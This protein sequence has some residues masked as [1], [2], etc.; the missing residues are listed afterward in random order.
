MTPKAVQP[1]GAAL[2]LYQGYRYIIVTFINGTGKPPTAQAELWWQGESDTP[3]P[4]GHPS[5]ATSRRR[6]RLEQECQRLTAVLATG[7]PLPTVLDAL[8]E[9]GRQRAALQAQLD[10]LKG[11]RRAAVRWADDGLAAELTARL[12]EWQ[13]VLSGQPVLSRQ[14]LRKLLVGR[15]QLTPHL[16]ADGRCYRWTGHASYGRLLAG[17][18]G[19][20]TMVPPG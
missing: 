14:I 12:G 1:S 10:H 11:L 17:L 16:S 4:S 8:R 9:R 6:R 19:V 13:T 20:Q 15:L 3:L 2:R 7:E 18:I 5:G